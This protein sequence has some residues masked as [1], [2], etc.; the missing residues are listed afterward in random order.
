MG[1]GSAEGESEKSDR[2]P[3]RFYQDVLELAAAKPDLDEILPNTSISW[4]GCGKVG[5]PIAYIDSHMMPEGDIPGLAE[6]FD[7][8]VEEEG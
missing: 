7:R 6:K 1:T 3:G 4:S 5:F 8:W 2:S